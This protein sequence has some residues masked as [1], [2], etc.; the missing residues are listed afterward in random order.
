MN[1]LPTRRDAREWLE[2]AMN[3]EVILTPRQL[4]H[5]DAAAAESAL[6][7]FTWTAPLE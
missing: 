5:L 1:G 2:A 6:G 7:E 3:G 4:D